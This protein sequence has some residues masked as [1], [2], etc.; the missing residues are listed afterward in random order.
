MALLKSLLSIL[1]YKTNKNDALKKGI[2]AEV[3][4]ESN[5]NDLLFLIFDNLCVQLSDD[6]N[7]NYQ[8]VM[9]WNKSKRSI[10]I[11]WLLEAEVNNGGFNQFYFNSSGHYYKDVPASLEVVGAT[12]FADL[13][14]DV[15]EVYERENEKITLHLDGTLEGF[16]KSYE[17]NPLNEFDT[18]FYNLYSTEDLQ[19]LQVDFVRKNKL[20][21]AN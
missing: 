12:K 15:N 14:R 9:S 21:F 6:Y 20:D 11:V 13:V 19:Q 5:D 18:E 2:M 10:Y 7:K 1:G 8:T 16:S 3:I 17:D 4:D